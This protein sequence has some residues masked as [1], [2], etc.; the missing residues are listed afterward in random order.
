[1]LSPRTLRMV[2][3]GALLLLIHASVSA[4]NRSAVLAEFDASGAGFSFSEGI[5][6]R[7]FDPARWQ[8]LDPFSRVDFI[9]DFPHGIAANNATA[10]E[11]FGGKGGVV[12]MGK[13]ELGDVLEAPERGYKPVLKAGALKAGHTYCFLTAD[14]K[15]YAKLHL[16]RVD[17]VRKEIEF[18]WQFQA[19]GTRKFD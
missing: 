5:V 2:L 11:H 7:I 3:S 16:M 4:Q 9:I 12:D 18:T 17:T 8:P 10:L 1:M 14:G 19:D 6:I 13:R 15:H